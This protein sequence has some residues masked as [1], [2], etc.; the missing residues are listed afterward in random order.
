M[1]VHETAIHQMTVEFQLLYT[2]PIMS[3]NNEPEA[4]KGPQN[5]NKF[6]TIKHDNLHNLLKYGKQITKND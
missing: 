6:E 3:F 1:I 5:K 2:G 4:V